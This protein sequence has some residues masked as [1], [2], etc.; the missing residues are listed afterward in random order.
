MI[1]VKVCCREKEKRFSNILIDRESERVLPRERER[2]TDKQRERKS[3]VRRRWEIM[4]NS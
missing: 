4:I 1:E 3:K 2:R